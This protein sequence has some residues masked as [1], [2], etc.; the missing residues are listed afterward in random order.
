MRILPLALLL[1]AAAPSPCGSFLSVPSAG[2]HFR[3][4]QAGSQVCRAPTQKLE[5][6]LLGYGA[7]AASPDTRCRMQEAPKEEAKQREFDLARGTAVDTL[8]SDYNNLFVTPA[9][10]TI[11][12][13]NIV[14]KDAQGFTLEGLKTYKL[15]FKTVQKLISALFSDI[16]V[17]V[18]LMDKYG[19]ERSKIKL[20]WRIELGSRG[21]NISWRQIW[22]WLD[23][24]GDGVIS[25]AEV[26]N[27]D[28]KQKQQEQSNGQSQQIKGGATWTKAQTHN[29]PLVL[30][31][32]SEYKLDVRGKIIEHA[33]TISYPA[34]PWS[35]APLRELL[36][37]RRAPGL[38]GVAGV[39]ATTLPTVS[40]PEVFSDPAT[41]QP[42]AAHSMMSAMP[43]SPLS[44]FLGG[45]GGG[46]APRRVVLH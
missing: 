18:L 16:K 3:P 19:S 43:P 8:L 22:G 37:V 28:A 17:S 29:A 4:V 38:A 5:Q 25:K 34:S 15:F 27:L 39:V 9:D 14:L 20:R 45:G 26:N 44:P 11:F 10:Y 6:S 42:V 1:A 21:P 35:L 2:R 33:I 46:Y 30:E 31:G 32:I 24:N 13:D 36:P 41:K 40:I 23:R 12:H 7:M